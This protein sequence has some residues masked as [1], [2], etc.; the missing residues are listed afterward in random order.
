MN[1]WEF[2]HP[3]GC[4]VGLLA[5][6]ALGGCSTIS[7]DPET[8]SQAKQA[9]TAVPTTP[10]NVN[11]VLPG[12]VNSSSILLAASNQLT[13]NG[14]GTVGDATRLTTVAG[15]G[16][17]TQLLI[18]AGSRLFANV[19]SGSPVTVGSN[20][21]VYGSVRS[22][23][24]VDV[25]AGAQ[26]LGGVTKNSAP[27]RSGLSW[28]VN[29]PT[30]AGTE[31]VRQAANG[32][33][34]AGTPGEPIAPGHY[35]NF[36]VMSRNRV[37]FRTG[38]YYIETFNLEPEAEIMIDSTNGPV[39][40]YVESSFRY[41]G[42]FLPVRDTSGV[43]LVREGGLRVGYL[44]TSGADITGPFV[45]V[46]VA[47]NADIALNSPNSGQHK[48]A[49]FGKN[50]TVSANGNSAL[51]PLDY[52]LGDFATGQESYGDADGDGTTD[53]IDFCPLDPAKT[54]PGVC[55]CLVPD[56]DSN[57]DGIPNCVGTTTDFC[58]GQAIGAPCYSG[59]CPNNKNPNTCRAN[60]VC[61]DPVA[62]CSP[63]GLGT[64]CTYN[65]YKGSAYWFCNA[66]VTWQAANAA[67]QEVTRRN[68]VQIDEGTE[69]AWL[70]SSTSNNMWI[71]A[72]STSASGTWSWVQGTD[73]SA[74]TFWDAGQGVGG[75][76]RHWESG[77]PSAGSCGAMQPD[78]TW[79]SK[80][81]AT[82]QGFICEQPLEDG[83][84]TSNFGPCEFYPDPSCPGTPTP[85]IEPCTPASDIMAGTRENLEAVAQDCYDKCNDRTKVGTPDCDE[86]CQGI[87][88]IA[89]LGESCS[90]I[91]AVRPVCDIEQT[92]YG[93]ACTPN[94]TVCG[95]GQTCGRVYK[96]AQLDGA[97]NSIPCAKDSDC[98]TNSCHPTHKVCIDPS[99]ALSDSTKSSDSN[100]CFASYYCGK[101]VAG[102]DADH[103]VPDP[104]P[105][106]EVKIC[107]PD[108]VVGEHIDPQEAVNGSNLTKTVFDP[109]TAFQKP[110]APVTTPYEGAKP[111]GCGTVAD[112]E[113]A[114][115]FKTDHPW[116][117]PQ[118]NPAD[119]KTKPQAVSDQT[120][121]GDKQGHSG[122]SGKV[123]FDFDPNLTLNYD[124]TPTL[125]GD[126]DFHVDAKATASATVHLNEFL[127][128]TKSI[129]VLDALGEVLVDRCG[130]KVD[131][132]TKLFGID[133]LPAIMQGNYASLHQFDTDQN[134]R[135]QCQA[136]IAQ[137]QTEVARVVKAL[138]DAQ[139]LIR[140]Y[141]EAAVTGN[142]LDANFCG[143]V[144][145]GYIPW[146]FPPLNCSTAT[147]D[148]VVNAFID[149]YAAQATNLAGKAIDTASLPTFG[150]SGVFSSSINLGGV[151]NKENQNIVN[152]PFTIGPIPMSLTI[153]AMVEYGLTGGLDF[154]LKP[155]AFLE[156]LKDSNAVGQ[157]AFARAHA[158]PHAGAGVEMF[159]GAGFT[160][161]FAEAR[162]GIEGNVNIADIDMPVTAGATLNVH[163][164]PENR[165]L[166]ADLEAAN[167][168]SAYSVYFPTVGPSRFRFSAGYEY[169][170][171][172]DISD[173]LHGEIDAALKLRFLFFS[174]SWRA[175]IAEF[176]GMGDPDPY[177]LFEGH[178]GMPG[179]KDLGG[180]DIGAVSMPV[181]FLRLPHVS[182]VI[183]ADA[184]QPSAKVK[185]DSGRVQQTFYDNQC[186][187]HPPQVCPQIFETAL[188]AY[189]DAEQS[190]Y[191]AAY[192]TNSFIVANNVR[193][194]TA[195]DKA[196]P[197]NGEIA[198]GDDN[199]VGTL[200]TGDQFGA[201]FGGKSITG[202][203][204]YPQAQ[205]IPSLAGANSGEYQI[206]TKLPKII[207][208]TKVPGD[209]KWNKPLDVTIGQGQ[210]E[211]YLSGDY[212]KRV[213]VAS[214][215]TLSLDGSGTYYFDELNV[216]PGGVL[217][218][219]HGGSTESVEVVIGTKL[220]W[221]GEL[222]NGGGHDN[223]H[224]IGYYGT[225]D[226]SG[227]FADPRY[228]AATW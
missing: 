23:G 58:S 156:T 142:K 146:D 4:V 176:S 52:T 62:E 218:I 5:A 16:S 145:N 216:N 126:S 83:Y 117:N 56:T 67:C 26:A 200:G 51:L 91:G 185:F 43:P 171:S 149:Y 29:W 107:N 137:F 30:D 99:V 105:C 162:V 90:H 12:G 109:D 92:G 206:W 164:E 119:N 181:P 57:G 88:P 6:V 36:N 153:D 140:Q 24:N 49:I 17:G 48:G 178:G 205:W 64:A 50:I 209:G 194:F 76:Y 96:C 98:S 223:A 167:G 68:L 193:L 201:I 213:T 139:E 192:G 144:I 7:G 18:Q 3:W 212:A 22:G 147:P 32:S 221:Q 93:A 163:S 169:D 224:I 55:G 182:A 208:N 222:L 180:V 89:A 136:G 228:H 84:P 21:T 160:C 77:Q 128:F 116:C 215:G 189:Y 120:A 53:D 33:L 196:S 108:E 172:V 123:T 1:R 158:T 97:G 15:L 85:T 138:R 102:C 75:R 66:A 157:V 202:L 40:V 104:Q 110:E 195:Y 173:I 122:G 127:G 170:A 168:T 101:P 39:I 37:M 46:L 25:Q 111:T 114:C 70:D 125:F 174:K 94:V 79:V 13:L 95:T 82:T 197:S 38:T 60:G 188:D 54:K 34:A 152:L 100:R 87:V 103:F 198:I 226:C 165:P 132:H 214:G 134:T 20:A 161:A 41:Y 86:H 217:K 2:P 166:P 211:H 9:V 148:T 47:P 31:I 204:N 124:M 78:G 186:A 35:S 10:V 151:T 45:G 71:G 80:D 73:N 61:G 190:N 135:T 14:A 131:A 42:K 175:K 59:I 220:T 69:N 106:N 191:L 112:G 159:V 177:Q 121:G 203:G 63:G 133:F 179:A 44:G 65:V 219:I 141:N 225:I 183:P 187:V 199:G 155:D 150:G 11:L 115:Q 207:L 19:L 130:L 72:N 81:C 27:G 28:V 227:Y 143:Q 74:F 210:T 184:G 8:S 113:S 129:P 118:V 154:G